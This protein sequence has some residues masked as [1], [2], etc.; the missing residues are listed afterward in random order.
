MTTKEINF[1]NTNIKDF[2]DYIITFDNINDILN[3]CKSQSEKGFIFEKLFDIIIKFG[4]C[5]I[6]IKSNFNHLIGNSSR[7]S[8][9]ILQNKNNNIFIFIS[10][11][12]SK[13]DDV[14]KL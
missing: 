1:T 9:S 6:F 7:C 13:S 5:D 3:T 8:D 14:Q 2:I 11:K 12:Y 4:F 10:S